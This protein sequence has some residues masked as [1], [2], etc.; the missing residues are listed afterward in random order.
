MTERVKSLR[1][2]V[3][4]EERDIGDVRSAIS[5][6]ESAL[7]LQVGGKVGNGLLALGLVAGE[8]EDAE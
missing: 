7:L 4:L 8:D 1:S 6:E 2:G 3:A 5:R